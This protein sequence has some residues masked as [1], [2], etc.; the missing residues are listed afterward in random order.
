MSDQ[1]QNLR[2]LAVEDLA[3]TSKEIGRLTQRVSCLRKLIDALDGIAP[4]PDG[5]HKRRRLPEGEKEKKA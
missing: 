4:K 2:E 1:M 3:N 5:R